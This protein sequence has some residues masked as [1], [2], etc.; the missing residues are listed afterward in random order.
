MDLLIPS[1][2]P[3]LMF[4]AVTPSKRIDPQ[5]C[6]EYS[7]FVFREQPHTALPWRWV[8]IDLLTRMFLPGSKD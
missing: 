4:G 1:L 5:S 7:G 3:Q 8:I 2:C 6:D